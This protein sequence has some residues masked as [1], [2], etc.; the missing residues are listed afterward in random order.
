M[1]AKPTN[2]FLLLVILL[3]FIISQE[4]EE[5]REII[6]P[7]EKLIILEYNSKTKSYKGKAENA[8]KIQRY[9]LNFNN[10][11]DIP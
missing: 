4:E 1:A 3:S 11:N 7:L 9:K 5:I 8:F 10:I 2:F 6:E